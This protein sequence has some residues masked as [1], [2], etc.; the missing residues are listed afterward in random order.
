MKAAHP[1]LNFKGNTEEAFAFYKTVFGGEYQG[2]IRFG[3]FTNNE[4]GVKEAELNKIAHVALPIAPNVLLMGTDVVEGMPVNFNAGNNFYVSL[5]P[6]DAGEAERVLGALSE[7]GRVEM[8]LQATPWA[9]K[10]GCLVD[11]FGVGWMV[12]YAGSVQF[13]TV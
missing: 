11:R 8:P 5:D 9:E 10:Y 13:A 3:D 7:G 2:L 1:Y 6:E 12:S 4:M